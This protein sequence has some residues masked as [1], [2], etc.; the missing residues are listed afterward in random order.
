MGNVQHLEWRN[1][2]LRKLSTNCEIL[3][4]TL[5]PILKYYYKL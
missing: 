5:A 1:L 3:L 2:V 4:Q